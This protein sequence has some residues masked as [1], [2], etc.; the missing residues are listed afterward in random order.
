MNKLFRNNFTNN[1]ILENNLSVNTAQNG[2]LNDKEI[3]YFN[4]SQERIYKIFNDP[5]L[6]TNDNSAFLNFFNDYRESKKI[7]DVFKTQS[8][9]KSFDKFIKISV[10]KR[11]AE[12][13]KLPYFSAML[14][15]WLDNNELRFFRMDLK[16]GYKDEFEKK[17]FG[18]TKIPTKEELDLFLKENKTI[19]YGHN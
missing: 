5:S 12:L 16:I 9:P 19:E 11:N 2:V 17:Y 10:D 15:Y 1:F 7:K 3:E 14:P 6:E 4:K 13:S 18:F 8:L